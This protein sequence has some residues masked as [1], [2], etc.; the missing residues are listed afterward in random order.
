MHGPGYVDVDEDMARLRGETRADYLR[1]LNQEWLK[2]DLTT[3]WM[4]TRAPKYWNEAS[5][6]VDPVEQVTVPA[7]INPRKGSGPISADEIEAFRAAERAA[8]RERLQRRW[9]NNLMHL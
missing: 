7:A 6:V 8:F 2:R 4:T 3:A 5:P 9:I 1:A